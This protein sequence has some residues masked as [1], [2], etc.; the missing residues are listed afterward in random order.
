LVAYLHDSVRDGDLVLIKGSRRNSDFGGVARLLVEKSIQQM[1]A[2]D[3]STP[4]ERPCNATT[5]ADYFRGQW[6]VRPTPDWTPGRM[7]ASLS[8]ARAGDFIPIVSRKEKSRIGVSLKHINEQGLPSKACLITDRPV[9]PGD[10]SI[11]VLKVDSIQAAVEKW[12]YNHR[13]QYQGTLFS[14]T[15]SVGKSTTTLMLSRMLKKRGR[16][17]VNLYDN[18]RSGIYRS[19]CTLGEQDFAVFEIA[20]GS[21]PSSSRSLRPD[22]AILLSISPAHMERHS[23]LDALVRCKMQIFEG[24]PGK[25]IAVISRDIP[26][27]EI[28]AAH[29]QAHGRSIITFGKHK[30]SDFKLVSDDPVKRTFTFTMGGR[31]YECTQSM[32]GEHLSLNSLAVIASVHAAGLN[33]QDF[34]G[35]LEQASQPPSGRGNLISVATGDGHSTFL[36]HS[37]NSNPQSLKAALDML[38]K[39][40]AKTDERKIAVLSDMLELGQE[41]QRYHEE[42]ADML[43]ASQLDL[44]VLVGEHM[45]SIREKLP[46]GLQA[47]TLEQTNDVFTVLP[48]LLKHGDIV[49]LKGSNGTGLRMELR[50]YLDAL[51]DN[52]ELVELQ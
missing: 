39:W 46:D 28:A 38:Y 13:R 6:L 1:H 44:V 21:L 49:M 11:P 26:Y 47:I 42:I 27:Y 12:V 41:S 31:A 29:A 3:L 5:F 35:D 34:I 19:A 10:E 51:Q 14:I 22:I 40:P 37:Y 2:D 48:P 17:L 33:W 32:P 45:R 15:G 36:D 25:G 9:N 43:D 30:S 7:I 50:K 23:S 20:Q 18:L 52:V 16:C 8:K 4:T 24:N